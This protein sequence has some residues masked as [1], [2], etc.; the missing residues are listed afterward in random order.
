MPSGFIPPQFKN[1][2]RYHQ[3]LVVTLLVALAGCGSLGGPIMTDSDNTVTDTESN[4][5]IVV[6]PI[7][8]Q[9]ITDNVSAVNAT[10]DPFDTLTSLQQ[11]LSEANKTG[12]RSSVGITERESRTFVDATEDVD[13]VP[14]NPGVIINYRGEFY[15]VSIMGLTL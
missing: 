7:E 13:R 3:I 8:E 10:S 9:D 1:H 12:N 4:Q 5:S 15:R 6:V 14:D 2:Q 11:A